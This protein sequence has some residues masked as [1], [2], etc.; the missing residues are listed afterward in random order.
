MENTKPRLLG[1]Q[2]IISEGHM[3]A[4]RLN[5][6]LAKKSVAGRKWLKVAVLGA[7][8]IGGSVL[9]VVAGAAAPVA[10]MAWA[11]SANSDVREMANVE[12]R[13]GAPMVYWPALDVML[14]RASGPVAPE[15]V[16]NGIAQEAY[17]DAIIDYVKRDARDAD[18]AAMPPPGQAWPIDKLS[19]VQTPG[20]V[21]FWGARI[22][23]AN[24]SVVNWLGA[25]RIHNGQ[26]VVYTIQ[27]RMPGYVNSALPGTE[28]VPAR[29]IPRALAELLAVTSKK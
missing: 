16:A 5:S 25:R 7:A 9:L 8:L 2:K 23:R 28:L 20:G 21:I 17:L 13:N 24:G 18:S 10:V 29:E 27:T 4:A 15:Q 12:Q 1:W 3:W 26:P 6:P 19:R 11:K 14:A 22:V